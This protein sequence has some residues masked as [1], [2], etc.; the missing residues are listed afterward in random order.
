[1]IQARYLT[2]LLWRPSLDCLA[3]LLLP[4]HYLVDETSFQVRPCYSDQILPPILKALF[5]KKVLARD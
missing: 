4:L 2:W 1:M 3:C 5:N